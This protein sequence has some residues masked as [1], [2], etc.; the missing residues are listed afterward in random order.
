MKAIKILNHAAAEGLTIIVLTRNR[1][2]LLRG[3]LESLFDQDDPGI[4]LEFIVVDDG[5]SDGTEEMVRTLTASR[6]Q[7]KY[8]RQKHGGIAAARNTGIR[9][10]RYEWLAIVA[11][12]YLLPVHYTLSIANF[13]RDHPQAQIVR[14]KIVAAGGGFLSRVLHA[15]QEASVIRRLAPLRSRRNRLGDWRRSRAKEK[16]TI[17][18]DLEAAGAAAFHSR[19]F[20]QVGGFDES[21][22]RG[23]D[24]DFTRRLRAAGIPVHY[25]PFVHIGHRYDPSLGTAMKNAFAGGRASWRLRSVP[26]QK[27]ASWLTILRLGLHSGLA[28]LYWSCWRAWQTAGPVR[29]PLYLPVLLLIETSNRAGFFSECLRS[30]KQTPAAFHPHRRQ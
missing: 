4:P 19:V 26:G 8:V 25:S 12:D 3:C 27:P 16:I 13:F 2:E 28:A 5:S 1:R 21:F 11:D 20:R 24:S 14:F 18:H 22:R 30:K 15:Y 29:F 6:P 7:W 10:G 17:D 9:N 23:E